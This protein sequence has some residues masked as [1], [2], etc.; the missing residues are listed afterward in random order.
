M[1][2]V[3]WLVAWSQLRMGHIF[4]YFIKLLAPQNVKLH[5]YFDQLWACE[6]QIRI[7]CGG[8]MCCD[9]EAMDFQG[10]AMSFMTGP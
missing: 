3:H 8:A 2:M 4:Y 5:N 9:S 10:E 6:L 1:L 7:H